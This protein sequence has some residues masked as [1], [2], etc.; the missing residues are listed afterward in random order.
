MDL[1]SKNP[2]GFKS[3]VD[4]NFGNY[5]FLDLSAPLRICSIFTGAGGSGITAGSARGNRQTG[6]QE[7]AENL[8]LFSADIGE[9][10]MHIDKAS[11]GDRK[12]E[13]FKNDVNDKFEIS[14]ADT[15]HNMGFT[16][17]QAHRNFCGIQTGYRGAGGLFFP[18]PATD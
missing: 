17:R 3:V 8:L 12:S 14:K 4:S 13:N 11:G 16:D 5:S 1:K 15:I 2:K 9:H 18:L 7:T 6:A 10:M